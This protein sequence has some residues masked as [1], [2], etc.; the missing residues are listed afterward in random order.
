MPMEE[1]TIEKIFSHLFYYLI[2]Y[3]VSLAAVIGFSFFCEQMHSDIPFGAAVLINVLYFSPVMILG[4]VVATFR[5][6]RLSLRTYR[7]ILFISV[8]PIMFSWP[9][10]I[11]WSGE[12]VYSRNIVIWFIGFVAIR[13]LVVRWDDR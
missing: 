7:K 9:V 12:A 3:I 4:A 6:D 10:L 8:L 1:L 11:D 13:L 2:L 5:H